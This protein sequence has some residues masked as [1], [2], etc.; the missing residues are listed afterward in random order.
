MNNQ[1]GDR[2]NCSDPNCGCEIELK[3]PCNI[4]ESPSR[5]VSTH[6]DEATNPSS[7]LSESA[8]T[9][10]V[11]PAP[12]SVS[13]I[14][15]SGTAETTGE[16]VFGPSGGNDTPTRQERYGPVVRKA[17]SGTTSSLQSS[18][19]KSNRVVNSSLD[20]DGNLDGSDDILASDEFTVDDFADSSRSRSV[21]MSLICFCGS[22]MTQV[23]SRARAA[24][25]G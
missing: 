9:S 22:Q 11:A 10:E 19:S 8:R 4:I 17:V 7:A 2:Y 13:S 24:R 23:E 1:V 16:G 25:A 15:S 12:G 6:V 18:G 14:R 20:P 3:S 5:N 21:S